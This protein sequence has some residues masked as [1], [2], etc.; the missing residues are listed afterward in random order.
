MKKYVAWFLIIVIVCLL[1]TG[2]AIEEE[3]L[4]T[5]PSFTLD[6]IVMLPGDQVILGGDTEDGV[7]IY[8]Y[9]LNEKTMKE[10]ASQTDDGMAGRTFYDMSWDEETASLV[11]LLYGGEGADRAQESSLLMIS[12][13]ELTPVATDREQAFAVCSRDHQIIYSYVSKGADGYGAGIRCVTESREKVWEVEIGKWIQYDK[14][15]PFGAGVLCMGNAYRDHDSSPQGVLTAID[16]DG[17]ILWSYTTEDYV[18]YVDC[19]VLKDDSVVVLGNTQHPDGPEYNYIA[20]FDQHGLKWEERK[21]FGSGFLLPRAVCVVDDRV[22]YV[23]SRRPKGVKLNEFW[24]VTYSSGGTFLS[25][26]KIALEHMQLVRKFTFSLHN[27]SIYLFI[28]GN[29]S[30]EN[31]WDNQMSAF[32][33]IE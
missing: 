7:I 26:E 16:A 20:C 21:E 10:I 17:T 9:D 28:S 2:F 8:G 19:A 24:L 14:I 31:R 30:E 22:L 3:V 12:D 32:I 29:T 6:S 1:Q 18:G 13:D 5:A 25:E 23:C 33:I 15:I 4:S 11:A 27:D